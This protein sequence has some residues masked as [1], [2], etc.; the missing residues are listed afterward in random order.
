MKWFLIWALT[1]SLL[2]LALLLIR[3]LARRKASARAIYALW[4]FAALRLLIPGSISVDA[5]SVAAAVERAPVVQIADELDGA[6]S[7]EYKPT[8]EVEARF[9][10]GS[11]GPEIVAEQVTQR[12]FDLISALLV[13]K[14]LVLPLWLTGAG[15]AALIFAAS[16]LR[17]SRSL[18]RDRRPLGLPGLPLAVYVS[19]AVDT[20]CLFGL[21]RP[22]VY[23][24]AETAADERLLRHAI[25]HEYS[26]FMQFD[27]IWGVLRAVCLALHWYNPLV[28]LAAKLSR[29]DCELACDEAA[30]ERLGEDERADY[31]RSLIRLTCERARGSAVATTMCAGPRE[32]KERIRM[33]T[34]K[35]HSIAALVLAALLSVT[36]TACS[37]AG[38]ENSPAQNAK[39]G[40]LEFNEAGNFYYFTAPEGAEYVSVRG[41]AY[42]GGEWTLADSGGWDCVQREGRLYLS[43]DMSVKTVAYSLE[44]AG[45]EGAS[46]VSGMFDFARGVEA[47]SWSMA[48]QTGFND[49]PELEDET[50]LLM[51][52]AVYEDEPSSVSESYFDNPELIPDKSS[53]YYCVTV[54][55]SANPL[56][57]ARL[58][59]RAYAE[60][61]KM[62]FDYT[63]PESAE[64]MAVSAYK[65]DGGGW[66]LFDR[67]VYP[68]DKKSGTLDF[69][70]DTEAQAVEFSLNGGERKTA[71]YDVPGLA[72][73]YLMDAKDATLNFELPVLILY[74][75]SDGPIPSAYYNT[76]ELDEGGSYVC[77]TVAFTSGNQYPQSDETPQPTAAP[78][79]SDMEGFSVQ[80]ASGSYDELLSDWVHAYAENLVR[81][82]LSD[83]AACSSVEIQG[84]EPVAASLTEPERIIAHMSLD[85]YPRDISAFE[86]AFAITQPVE[87]AVED[88]EIF[89]QLNRNLVLE[90]ENGIL[91]CIAVSTDSPDM[92]GYQSFEPQSDPDYIV[93]MADAGMSA[94]RIVQLAN[95]SELNEASAE[96][97][98]AL[99]EALDDIAIAPEG[100][101]DQLIRDMYAMLAV[102]HADGAYASWLSY[103]YIAQREHDPE[104]F[105]AAL[106]A[107]DSETR[108]NIIFLADHPT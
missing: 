68:L 51:F 84:C 57:T 27:H 80:T 77:F 105:E 40:G 76:E 28:W 31:G 60:Y 5:P 15:A 19:G 79:S 67:T 18:R 75:G 65:F 63:A 46:G 97:W 98:M 69:A 59:P 82:P 39:P 102:E 92:W 103:I 22:A 56:E 50:V 7:I 101:N 1:A 107:F 86:I 62:T 20:P 42:S 48:R 24:P 43:R 47:D 25:A 17:F 41:W 104:T 4:L 88:G 38:G 100:A 70:A 23:V 45:P 55:F 83:P 93:K 91:K 11:A 106:S 12:E 74:S 44:F 29:R 54:L 21:V 30:I 34:R 94:A 95:Y 53:Y 85:C 36:A 8:G 73:A 37:F 52:D 58:D 14:R 61:G 26:H 32:L 9:E 99:L 16:Y 87:Y 72:A 78:Q 6:E 2:I 89:Y 64:G 66:A 35:S 71:A 13:L 49:P 90:L 96:S 33:L 10:G 3:R 108:E 81:L